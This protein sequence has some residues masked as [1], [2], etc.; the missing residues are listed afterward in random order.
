MRGWS[1]VGLAEESADHPSP[2]PRLPQASVSLLAESSQLTGYV[3]LSPRGV[4]QLVV[5]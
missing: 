5:R 1:R 2:A 3:A 4:K